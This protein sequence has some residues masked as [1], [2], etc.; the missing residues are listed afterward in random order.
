MNTKIIGVV[1]VI[2]VL[3]AIWL[4]VPLDGIIPVSAA[5]HTVSDESIKNAEQE[6]M[7]GLKD[8][9][10]VTPNV[11]KWDNGDSG[12]FALLVHNTDKGN[13]KDFFVNVFLENVGNGI[14]DIDKYKTSTSGWF[15]FN[16]RLQLKADEIKTVNM[17]T[18]PSLSSDSGAYIFRIVVCRTDG[19]ASPEAP[20]DCTLGA[21]SH[22]Y[23]TT[24]FAIQLN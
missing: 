16:K 4:F 24:S 8:I 10:L 2:I 20:E 5:T 6:V 3:I 14:E 12:E 13:D 21:G 7:A 1:I 18:K 22:I 19:I 17:I 23:S 15:T 9:S 11:L